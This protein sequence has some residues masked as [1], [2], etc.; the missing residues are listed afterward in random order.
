[1]YKPTL[2]RVDFYSN[3]IMTPI[4]FIDNQDTTKHI[5][6]VLSISTNSLDSKSTLFTCLLSDNTIST[7]VYSN[8][9]WYHM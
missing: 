4:A 8:S 1:M 6:K 5:R 3:G 9:N 7:L 2:V